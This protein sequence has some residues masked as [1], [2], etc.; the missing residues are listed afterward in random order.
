MREP[1]ENDFYSIVLHSTMDEG[2]N[3]KSSLL[4]DRIVLIAE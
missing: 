3:S 2:Y 1:D 4:P